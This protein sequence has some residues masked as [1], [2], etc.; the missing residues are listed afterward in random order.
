M[1][2]ITSILLF[3]PAISV[4]SESGIDLDK[5]AKERAEWVEKTFTAKGTPVPDSGVKVIQQKKMSTYKMLKSQINK[6][7]SDIKK[8]G[9]INEALPQIQSLLNFKEIMNQSSLNSNG[10]ESIKQNISDIQMAY[11]FRAIPVGVATSVYGFT[12]SV[13]YIKAKG[14]VGII[15]FFA[16]DNIGN[17]SFRENNLKFSHGAAIIPEEEATKE[18]NGKV[19]VAITTGQQDYGFMYSVDWYDNNFFRELKCANKKFKKETMNN[20]IELAKMIDN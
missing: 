18:V 7:Q 6:E 16:K 14:W 20:V 10:K 3:L 19:T 13:T 9:Y 17:C 11:E 8:Y 1:K 4:F 15:Q 12:P 5:I 2:K